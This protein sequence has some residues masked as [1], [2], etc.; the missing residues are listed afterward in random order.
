KPRPR[1]AILNADDDYCDYW[2]SLVKDVAVLRF[3]LSDAADVFAS[4]I[5]SDKG[6]TSFRLHLPNTAIDI[7]LPFLGIHNVQNA[8]AAAAVAVALNVSAEQIKTGLESLSPVAGRLQPRTGLR[9]ATLYDDSYNA[10][11]VSVRAAG[12]F[13][14]SLKGEKWMVLGDMGEL[15]AAAAD[16]HRDV[17][18][19]LQAAGIDRL[20]AVGTL[21][22]ETVA[23]FGARGEWFASID[24]LIARVSSELRAD[25]NVLVKGSRS[26][27]MERV[28]HAIRAPQAMRKEA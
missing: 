8:C 25:I 16:L 18:R 9:G 27:R 7:A 13:I 4:N 24:E 22:R 26:A 1:H 28:V 5:A 23:A 14:A 3:G 17:G 6:A 12:E 21:S 11:P 19:A 10:N 2:Q 20:F 15:G